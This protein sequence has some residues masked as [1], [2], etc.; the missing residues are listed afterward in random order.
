MTS[1]VPFRPAIA[2]VIVASGM[3]ESSVLS[4]CDCLDA[5]MMPSRP[6]FDTFLTI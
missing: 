2:V 1:S 3:S 5:F 4:A 6:T